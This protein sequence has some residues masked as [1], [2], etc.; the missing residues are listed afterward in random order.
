MKTKKQPGL[1]LATIN[2]WMRRVGLVFVV[3]VHESLVMEDDTFSF[4]IER[5]S[6]YDA[7]CVSCEEASHES[8]AHRL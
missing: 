2:L 7:R 1:K 5:A 8:G 4:W 3:C 6:K